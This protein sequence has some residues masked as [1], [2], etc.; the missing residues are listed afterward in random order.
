MVITESFANKVFG[1]ANPVGEIL[2]RPAGQYYAESAEYTVVGIMKDFPYQ[3]H[4]HPDFI[5]SPLDDS[6]YFQGWAWT[7]LLFYNNSDPEMVTSGLKDFIATYY[8]ANSEDIVTEAHL[9]NLAKIH[10]LSKKTREIEA[11][12]SMNVIYS[13]TSAFRLSFYR[14]DCSP[15]LL[16]LHFLFVLWGF[17]GSPC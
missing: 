16:V 17:L 9:Q 6:I 8:E 15:S 12:S 14:P 7:Y 1:S 10:L 2:I 11:N 4:F 13:F 5:T 3:S